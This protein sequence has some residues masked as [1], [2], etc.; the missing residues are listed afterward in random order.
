MADVIHVPTPLGSENCAPEVQVSADIWLDELVESFSLIS[1]PAPASSSSETVWTTR[2]GTAL[3]S[4]FQRI[5]EVELRG[6]VPSG[7]IKTGTNHARKGGEI[8]RA[9]I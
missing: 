1:L 6:L 8:R 5:D 2:V 4:V 3:D 9:L 7:D